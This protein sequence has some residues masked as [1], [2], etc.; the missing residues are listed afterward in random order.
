MNSIIHNPLNDIETT[1]T[2][3]LP[4]LLINNNNQFNSS[5]N[6]LLNQNYPLNNRNIKS[7]SFKIQQSSS[8]PMLNPNSS[9]PM[10]NH[11]NNHNNMFLSQ[12]N[13][14]QQQLIQSQMNQQFMQNQIQQQ[15]LINNQLQQQ[16]IQSQMQQQFIKQNMIQ[17]SLLQKQ[18]QQILS[19]KNNLQS[20][21][22]ISQSQE[23]NI[24]FKVRGVDIDV[25]T[26]PVQIHPDE[27]VSTLIDKYRNKAN[28]FEI[29]K[30]FIFN[31]RELDPFLTCA[32][33]GLNNY[34]VIQV[35]NTRDV[36]GAFISF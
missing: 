33:S 36:N 13:P 23:I 34:S 2:K 8:N 26:V 1:K 21:N 3:L 6:N 28:D 7:Q 9:N 11:N 35:I 25:S 12:N 16:L 24:F 30:K 19:S 4:N 31:A 15:Q 29:K 10:M 17:Q 27:R 5:K 18:M 14:M 22:N 32:E 20:N